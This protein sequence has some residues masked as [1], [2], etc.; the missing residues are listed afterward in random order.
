MD[1][2]AHVFGGDVE[3]VSGA[4]RGTTIRVRGTSGPEADV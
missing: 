1:E 2:R 4:A 3:V